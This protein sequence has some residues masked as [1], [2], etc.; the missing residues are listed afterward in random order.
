MVRIVEYQLH[1]EA[2]SVTET[3]VLASTLLDPAA[4]PAG[5]LA[6]LYHQRWQIETALGAF[7]S[8]LRGDG[9][10]LR[11][12]TPDG[13]EQSPWPARPTGY[14]VVGATRVRPNE[15]T[16]TPPRPPTRPGDRR[17]AVH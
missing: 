14:G 15:A 4:A 16:A 13:A 7:T 10:V 12:K 9:V 3:F 5:E 2:G 11:S 8:E 1:D 17:G 6:A